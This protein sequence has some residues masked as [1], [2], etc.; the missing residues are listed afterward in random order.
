MIDDPKNTFVFDLDGAMVVA[1]NRY[2]TDRT[3]Q[4][5]RE[6]FGEAFLQRHRVEIPGYVHYLFPG[7]FALLRWLH[8]QGVNLAFF[9]SGVEARNVPLVEH[10]MRRAFAEQPEPPSYSIFSRHHCIETDQWDRQQPEEKDR[11]Q[12]CF[13]GNLK[14]KLAG[15]VVPQEALEDTLL[16]DDDETFMVRGE[17]YNF[18]GLGYAHRYAVDDQG[19]DSFAIFH[20]AF[21]VAGFAYA[22]FECCAREGLRL[23]AAARRLQYD[24]EGTELSEEFRFPS[25]YRESYY[26]MGRDI[27]R[28]VESDIDFFWPPPVPFASPFASMLKG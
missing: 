22:V 24:A 23:Q 25:R 9:S 5:V 17:E 20:S 27:L 14:K 4:Q 1:V 26:L 15:I 8:A 19:S 18:V 16:I 28:Q 13:P 10:F 21:Y 7:Y 3:E 6:K 2:E 11:Y 12:P